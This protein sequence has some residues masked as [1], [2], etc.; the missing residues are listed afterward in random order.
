VEPGTCSKH[1][2]RIFMVP[3]PGGTSWRLIIDLRKIN[4]Y[5]KL[6]GM[7][8]ETLKKLRNLARRTDYMFSMD[9]ADGFYCLGLEE[10][11]RDYFTVSVGGQL[12]RLAALPMGWC[13]SPYYF[14]QLMQVWVRHLRSPVATAA[15]L[16]RSRTRG[17]MR[18]PASR[19]T[20]RLLP[21]VDDF[22]FLAS[23]LAAALLLRAR[24]ESL[25]T[26]LGLQ[27]NA[28]KGEWEP[29]QSLTHL[30]MRV[31]LKLGLFI[32]PAEKL[33]QIAA[34]AK[35]LLGRAARNRRFLPAK[36]LA[37]L[38]GKA[39]FLYLAIPVARFYLREL[40][41]VLGPRTDWSGQVKMSNQL[42]RDLRWWMAVPQQRNGSEIFTSLTTATLHTDS[43]QFGWGGV[44][45]S[46]LEARGFWH[47]PDTQEHI[48][49][50][51]LKAVRMAVE[52][53]LPH[54]TNRLVL[55]HEDNQAVVGVLSG[56]TSRSPAMMA[57]LRK[58][59]FLL[60]THNIWIRPEYIRSAANAWADRLSRETDTDDW[61]LNPRVF[62]MLSGLWGRPSLD[63]FASSTNRQLPRFYA[64]W[65]CP[66]AEGVDVL[67]RSP[68]DWR[69]EH[70]WCNPPWSLLE[71]LAASLRS[72]GA[73]ATVIAPYWPDAPWFAA[74]S[75]LADAQQRLPPRQSLFR[76]GRAGGASAT[77]P[78][79]WHVQCWHIPLRPL[80]AA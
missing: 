65:L 31:D 46:S 59:W 69:R 64:R 6:F 53:F 68:A 1:V 78:P 55:L 2:S 29:T 52:C 9:V 76:S 19:R 60:D 37:A 27:R 35:S 61:Q 14:C 47:G 48:T 11:V 63:C 58:L 36:A 28:K 24:V 39:Q 49:W 8:F 32:A 16:Q 74:L 20:V 56:L 40:H 7:K 25:L 66:G 13:L 75:E 21:Y 30:G 54:L 43:S 5:C 73:E 4:L 10:S 50:K 17:K 80:P 67:A 44:L 26:S 70:N 12:W 79:N 23:S 51:E 42:Q 3:K 62:A 33:L 71:E 15:P 38:A 57:E 41:T 34:Q 45:N 18:R 72:S 77:A 22:L